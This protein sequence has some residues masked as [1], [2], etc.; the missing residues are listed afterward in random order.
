MFF[1]TSKKQYSGQKWLHFGW[2]LDHFWIHFWYRAEKW[3][4]CSRLARE[5]NYH[6][7]GGPFFD[8]FLGIFPNPAPELEFLV[9]FFQIF[10]DLGGPFGSR[11]E[12]VLGSVG[13]SVLGEPQESRSPTNLVVNWRVRGVGK[14]VKQ[15]Q[16][17]S[18]TKIH[19]YIYIS[20]SR[21]VNLKTRKKDTDT[22]RRGAP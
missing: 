12:S 22:S 5:H 14:T 3:K 17:A 7:F 10:D 13:R 6:G 9:F 19:I 16:I 21:L 8:I 18:R 11:W 2:F 20:I 1:W 15:I 4:W